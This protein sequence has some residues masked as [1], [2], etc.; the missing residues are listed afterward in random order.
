MV[1]ICPHTLNGSHKAGL[2][3]NGPCCEPG[4]KHTTRMHTCMHTRLRT[5]LPRKVAVSIHR[6]LHED[7]SMALVVSTDEFVGVVHA[8][9]VDS[10]PAGDGG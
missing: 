9:A 10:K 3:Q 1:V 2:L 7:R 4:S 5:H 8:G 6:S